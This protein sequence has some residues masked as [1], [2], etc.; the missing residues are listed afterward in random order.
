[1]YKSAYLVHPPEGALIYPNES[2]GTVPSLDIQLVSIAHI[3]SQSTAMYCT[4]PLPN[5]T[6]VLMFS[7]GLFTVLS[8]NYKTQNIRSRH[9]IHRIRSQ[10]FIP[11]LMAGCQFFLQAP[12]CHPFYVW[13]H[14]TCV[15]TPCLPSVRL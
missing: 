6:P 1:L 2:R 12:L 3:I 5:R 7:S 13:R 9:N 14:G 15:P 4:H 10:Y 8:M 11:K